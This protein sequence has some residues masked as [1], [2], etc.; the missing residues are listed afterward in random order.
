[1]FMET[2][3]YRVFSIAGI[4]VSVSPGY[5]FLM[6]MLV[7]LNG[8]SAGAIFAAVALT[9]SVLIHE[10][11]HAAISHRYKLRPSILLHGF[12]GLCFHDEA[13]TDGKDA[14]IVVM[15]PLVEIVAGALALVALVVVPPGAF[16]AFERVRDFLSIFAIFSLVWGAANLF[17][18][19]W[20]L[21]GGKLFHL[22]LRRFTNARQARQ[23]ALKVSIPTIILAGGVAF[24]HWHMLL[25]PIMG[26]FLIIENVQALQHDQPLVQRGGGASAARATTANPF[27][28]EL[29]EDARAAMLRED[30]REAARLCHQARAA[31]GALPKQQMDTVW[32]LLGLATARAGEHEE[33]LSYLRRAPQTPQVTEAVAQCEQALGGGATSR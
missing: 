22:L 17:L 23:I 21:D 6:I 1:M 27:V 12:G 26:L 20:P 11:G 16:G 24:W 3:G 5:I 32:T 28:A 7:A 10:L 30:W 33:A 31:S 29:L 2:Q 25:V 14:L 19:I 18:P 13:P 15:G 8:A 9:L 4:D